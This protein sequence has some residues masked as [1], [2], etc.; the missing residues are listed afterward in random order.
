M[1][2]FLAMLLT[3]TMVLGMSLAVMADDTNENSGN[4]GS[5]SS[6]AYTDASTVTFK[7]KYTIKNGGENPAETF[8]FTALT[9]TEVSDTA[10]GVTKADAPIPTIG[11]AAYTE[12]EAAT[13]SEKEVTI[14]LPAVTA[15]PSVGVYTY[16]FKENVP[17][18]KTAGVTYYEKDMKLVV[19][20][21]EDGTK[22]RI[23]A[24]HCESEGEKTDVFENT[25]ESG[26]LAVTK[27]VT[28]N[29]GDKTKYFDVTVSF[30][31]PAGTTIGSTIKY[32]GG[33]Y[34]E[35]VAVDNN[36]ATIQ[37]KDGDTV[38]FENLPAGVTYTVNESD[39]TAK[40][41][42]EYDDAAYEFSD[43]A[44]AI[45]AGD[46]DTCTITNNKSAEIDTGIS[47]DSLPYIVMIA[48]V[49][50]AAVAFFMKKRSSV[51]E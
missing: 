2:K 6:A 17:A 36:T 46:A 16:T 4:G 22:K 29:L 34:T 48:V 38:T 5:G 37:V 35:K 30:S 8:T 11:N 9:C 24:V 41:N 45:A 10:E 27:T 43:T 51:E 25:Y 39:Y 15:F 23:A 12:N 14:T 40:A 28:G 21:V 20:I 31:A 18:T 26:T 19:S 7:K 13:T 49:A 50:I 33:K 3:L 32:S 42:G 47:M 44:K 1:K